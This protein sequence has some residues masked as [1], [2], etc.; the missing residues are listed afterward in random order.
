VSAA[1][2]AGPAAILARPAVADLAR[3][4]ARRAGAARLIVSAARDALAGAARTA[5]VA[6]AARTA[7]VAER[8]ARAARP[9]IA[10]EPGIASVGP[11]AWLSVAAARRAVCGGGADRVEAALIA[12]GLARLRLGISGVATADVARVT[13]AARL[14]GTPAT[15]AQTKARALVARAAL[16]ALRKT[17]E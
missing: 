5:A 1:R 4:L 7:L 9:G 13:L 6:P 8:T 16:A 15:G 12:D 17:R 10:R 11:T 14:T 3:A 2:V